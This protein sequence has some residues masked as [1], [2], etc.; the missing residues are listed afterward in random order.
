MK[1][2]ALALCCLVL[3]L[4]SCARRPGAG[5]DGTTAPAPA[6]SDGARTAA[7]APGDADELVVDPYCGMRL[8]RGEAAASV[9]IRGTTY[10]FCL[11]DHRDAFLADP[12]RALCRLAGAD[13]GPEC[14]AR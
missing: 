14:D 5:S 6:A 13:A 11:A 7:G 4:S 2:P 9:E 1:P 8:K 3:A 12:P 10:Y